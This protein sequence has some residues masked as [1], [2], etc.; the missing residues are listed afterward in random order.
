MLRSASQLKFKTQLPFTLKK[1]LFTLSNSLFF[2]WINKKYFKLALNKLL[3]VFSKEP[4]ESVTYVTVNN[5]SRLTATTRL[6]CNLLK[7]QEISWTNWIPGLFS[8]FKLLYRYHRL[9]YNPKLILFFFSQ[10]SKYAWSELIKLPTHF[11]HII[12]V[13]PVNFSNI[14]AQYKRPIVLSLPSFGGSMKKDFH[15]YSIFIWLLLLSK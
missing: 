4:Y 6:I 11:R 3:P 5:D 10:Y 7:V 8:R 15:F 12:Q 14:Q 1:Y 2:V 9:K 13:T